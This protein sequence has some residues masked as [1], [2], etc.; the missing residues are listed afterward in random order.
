MTIQKTK[1]K[2]PFC[3]CETPA[4]Y[5]E[6]IC[7]MCGSTMKEWTEC[8]CC[9]E[10]N[11][12]E[13][14]CDDFCDKCKNSVQKKLYDFLK[15]NFTEK[16]ITAGAISASEG[17][18]IQLDEEITKDNATDILM[19]IYEGADDVL[20]GIPTKMFVPTT[21]TT[22]RPLVASFITLSLRRRT[23]KVPTTSVNSFHSRLRRTL[24]IFTSPHNPT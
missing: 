24:L 14:E 16:E 15:A 9:G 10:Y 21:R 7:C 22:C 18:F 13:G 17:N 20:Q 1:L 3:G 4:E 12:P 19:S 11:I 6:E 23:L 5:E 8:L 2:C